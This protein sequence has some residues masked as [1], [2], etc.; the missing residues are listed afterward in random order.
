LVED[1]KDR[2]VLKVQG[3]ALESFPRAEIEASERSPISLMPE[4]LEKQLPLPEIRDLIAF[5]C[6]DKPP[7]D[8]GA[9][10]IPGA[11]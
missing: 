11:P 2:V 1:S 4:G 9:R 7:S 6:L 8:P 10:K 5:L 3:G